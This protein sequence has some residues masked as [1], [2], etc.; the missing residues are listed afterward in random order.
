[1]R[2]GII[3]T[4]G[5]PNAYGGFE[6]FA[7]HFAV[8]MAKKGHEVSVYTSH[9]HPYIATQY[10]SVKLISCYDPEYLLGTAGQF[11]Y[12]LNCIR[13]C[14][15]RNFDIILQ[16]GY[17]SS[18]IWSWLY[19]KDAVLVTNMD[20]LEWKRTKYSKPVRYFLRY[21]EKWGVKFSNYL[22]ADS[23][24]IQEYLH[25]HYNA[26]S[27]Y[28][29]YGADL[30]KPNKDYHFALD[31]FSIKPYEYD[32]AI[33]R[34]E[35]EN[36]IEPILNAYAA[37]PGKKLLL[38]GNHNA[39]AFGR[40]MYKAFGKYKHIIFAGPVFEMAYLNALRH[41][42]R[43]YIHG[44]SVGGTNPSLLEAMACGPT[45]CAYNNIFNKYVLGNDA[46]Y[47]NDQNDLKGIITRSF[48]KEDHKQWQYNN[49]QKILDEYNWESVTEK[50]ATCFN[51]WKYGKRL[52][53]A[54]YA[55]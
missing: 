40:K 22:I 15:N 44:H 38:V 7:E 42:A 43:L 32:L 45:I 49:E 10:K 8:R 6:Q 53:Q 46:F 9:N 47:F 1:M 54:F 33:A 26:R 37:T 51:E 39:T 30:Y 12:D 19:P 35:P 41:Y 52:L 20:G 50:L 31:T 17:T 13:D 36:N 34:F 48:L 55:S 18:T 21:A 3:G 27:I 16:L 23:K 14:R 2:I 11:I 24:G 28:V 5:I 29:P 4:R 25:N